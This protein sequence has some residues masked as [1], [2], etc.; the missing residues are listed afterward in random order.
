[1]CHYKTQKIM[2][3]MISEVLKNNL[4]FTM[5]SYSTLGFNLEMIFKF[6]L[7]KVVVAVV[8]VETV[9]LNVEKRVTLAENVRREAVAV[10][11]VAEVVAVDEEASAIEVEEAAVVVVAS[12]RSDRSE[13]AVILGR[14]KK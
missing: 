8:V 14:I 10:V 13:A 3:S 2:L 5:C 6:I 12:A 9:A 11:V 1:M 4:K 7:L